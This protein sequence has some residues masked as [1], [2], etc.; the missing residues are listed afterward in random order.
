[1]MYSWYAGQCSHTDASCGW[2][3]SRW[4]QTCTRPE[5]YDYNYGVKAVLLEPCSRRSVRPDMARYKQL[6]M[7]ICP[8]ASKRFSK[9]MLATLRLNRDSHWHWLAPCRCASNSDLKH[10]VS[11]FLTFSIVY[12]L[13][14]ARTSDA[15]AWH[16]RSQ[17][18]IRSIHKMP[19]HD[20]QKA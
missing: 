6:T 16:K 19:P 1:M 17:T 11:C 8:Y 10:D 20:N 5:T 7:H 9:S 14:R 12:I 3:A 2:C 13:W 4:Q 18:L 15:R